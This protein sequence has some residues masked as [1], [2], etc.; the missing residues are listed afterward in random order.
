[1]HID[2][3]TYIYTKTHTD[4]HTHL[5]IYIYGYKK[6]AQNKTFTSLTGSWS[7]KKRDE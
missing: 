7:L 6:G 1:M 5:H 3:Y 4:I 2:I